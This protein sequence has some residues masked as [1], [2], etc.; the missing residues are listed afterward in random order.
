MRAVPCLFAR[1][2]C[3]LTRVVGLCHAFHQRVMVHWHI[4]RHCLILSRRQAWKLPAERDHIPDKTIIV[5]FSPPRHGSTL[6]QSEERRGGK[7]SVRPC[8]SRWAQYH[9]KKNINSNTKLKN[10]L[11]QN[12]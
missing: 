8:R 1:R 12:T 7:E 11:N 2:A 5:R 6:D 3:C 10:S 9:S 4:L